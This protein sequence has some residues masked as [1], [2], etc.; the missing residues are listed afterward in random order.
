MI[1]LKFFDPYSNNT[2][3]LYFGLILLV[4]VI[5]LS[6]ILIY[7][8][9][10]ARLSEVMQFLSTTNGVAFAF[11]FSI[12]T[13]IMKTSENVASHK[14]PIFGPGTIIYITIFVF[15]IVEPLLASKIEINYQGYNLLILIGFTLTI[16]S[17]S[18]V[19]LGFDK[20]RYRLSATSIVHSK[21]YC[22]FIKPVICPI[23]RQ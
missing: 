9:E 17:L 7:K 6:L 14:M 3:L 10:N 1:L 22:N 13:Y 20:F 12:G 5:T 23:L 11:I 21:L 18:L 16:L 8:P 15:S 19:P 2:I 4:I